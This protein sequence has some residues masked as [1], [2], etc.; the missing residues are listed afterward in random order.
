MKP[1]YHGI[2]DQTVRRYI[3]RVASVHVGQRCL[4]AFRYWAREFRRVFPGC[5]LGCRLHRE[6]YEVLAHYLLRY[7]PDAQE[8]VE[9]A[10]AGGCMVDGIRVE[11]ARRGVRRG[12]FA[13]YDLPEAG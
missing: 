9:R 3:D 5:K 8:A 1:S 10:I 2:L 11:V 13:F 6:T 4:L 7:E 12:E